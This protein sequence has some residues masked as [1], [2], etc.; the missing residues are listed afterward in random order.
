MVINKTYGSLTSTLSLENFTASNNTTAQVYQYSNA[1]LNAIAAQTPATV[2]PPA[3]GSTSSTIS[4][5]FPD[6]SITLFVIPN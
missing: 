5:T 2:T 6:Q 4:Y 3:G 1:N